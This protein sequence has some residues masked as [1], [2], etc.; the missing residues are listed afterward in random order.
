MKKNHIPSL[1][2]ILLLTLISVTFLLVGS[3][4]AQQAQPPG[5]PAADQAKEKEATGSN[6]PDDHRNWT[7]DPLQE[8]GRSVWYGGAALGSVSSFVSSGDPILDPRV[9]GCAPYPLLAR[10]RSVPEVSN[11]RSPESL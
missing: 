2:G 7:S 9:P 4:L 6:S 8:K 10:K 1:R 3:A 11:T 5:T